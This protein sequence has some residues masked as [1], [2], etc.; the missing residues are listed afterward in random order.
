[1]INGLILLYFFIG[2]FIGVMTINVVGEF[3]MS[4]VIFIIS[5]IFWLPILVAL[6]IKGE[7]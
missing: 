4:L 3:S 2:A 6:L 7:D 5:V 1:M